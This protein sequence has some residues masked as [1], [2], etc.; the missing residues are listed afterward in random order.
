M[1]KKVDKNPTPADIE[2]SIENLK[3]ILNDKDIT[4][5]N[6]TEEMKRLKNTYEKLFF[7]NK[8]F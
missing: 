3:N 6:F 5:E 2:I 4:T 1:D 7:G 8:I